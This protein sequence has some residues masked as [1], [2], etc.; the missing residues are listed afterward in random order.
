[1]TVE[2]QTLTTL[3][4]EAVKEIHDKNIKTSG[5]D[6]DY[7]NDLQSA[8]LIQK[9]KRSR[10]VLGLIMILFTSSLVWA[11]YA[12]VDE[13]TVA[14]ARVIPASREQL[15]QSLEGGVIESILVREGSI[16]KKDEPL[17]VIDATRAEAFV[18]ETESKLVALEA[19]AA[20]FRAESNQ[21][22][23]I[24]PQNIHHATDVIK[25]E[26]DAFNARIKGLEESLE[27][28]KVSYSLINDEI[29]LSEPLS[30]KGLI[31][32]VEILRMKRQANDIQL[33]I[34]DKRN[35]FS[36]QASAELSRVESEIGQLRESMIARKDVVDR[37]TIKSPVDGIVTTVNITTI[38]GVVPQGGQIMQIVPTGDEL[39]LEAKVKPTDMAFLKLGAPAVVKVSAYDYAIYGGLEGVVEHISSDAIEETDAN[40]QR[41]GVETYYRVLVRTDKAYLQR[42]VKRF[43]IIPGMTGIVQIKT[44]QKS[45]LSYIL[46]P[47]FKAREAFRER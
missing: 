34:L 29:S 32:N 37:S 43:E 36:S 12:I 15:I 26:T 17:A 8:L 39:L 4:S 45:I 35:Q 7:M 47:I 46:K 41:K 9:P 42:D 30:K 2:K 13:V 21:S 5:I 20:R 22:E 27:A 14:E 10:M 33:Q 16:V 1:M 18:R 23:L 40:A 19:Q 3:E 28:L 24:F 38:G 6:I 11:N 25:V 44:G 31:S